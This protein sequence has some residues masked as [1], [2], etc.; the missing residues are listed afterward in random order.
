MDDFEFKEAA[1][2]F[3]D[4][5]LQQL[6][7]AGR[8]GGARELFEETGIDVRNSL[9]RL[10]PAK[11]YKKPPDGKLGNEYKTRLFFTLHVTDKD[12]LKED[13][14]SVSEAAFL[15]PPMGTNPPKLKVSSFVFGVIIGN[16]IDFCDYINI[17]WT[18]TTTQRENFYA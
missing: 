4:D 2:L 6:L 15:R 17:I 5:P 8:M 13:N 16:R 3:P 11:L 7:H 10:A 12:F 1:K 18:G 14:V 9:N